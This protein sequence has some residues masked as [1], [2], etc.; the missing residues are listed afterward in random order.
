MG[1][2]SS[3]LNVATRAMMNS[4]NA[5]QTVSHNIASKDVEG[6]SRQ[7]VEF[8]TTP[9]V[10]EGNVQYG[11]GSRTKTVTRINNDYLEKQIQT[12]NSKLGTSKGRSENLLRV[13]SI[14]N[15]QMRKGVNQFVTEFFNSFRELANSP[16][17]QATRDLVKQTAN[18]VTEDFRRVSDQLKQVQHDVDI[19]LTAHTEEVNSML[20]EIA[21]LNGVIEHIEFT[22]AQANDERDRRDQVLKELGQKMNIRYSEG[23]SGK[24]NV[25]AGDNAIVVSG[26]E[27]AEL[28]AVSSGERGDKREGNVDIVFKYNHTAPSVIT[29]QITGGE[30]GGAIEVRDRTI[31]KLLDRMDKLAYELADNVNAAHRMGYNK[32]GKTQQDFF[33]LKGSVRGSAERLALSDKVEKD[34]WS[35]SAAAAPEAPGDNRVANLISSLQNQ[36]LMEKGTSTFNDYYNGIVSEMAVGVRHANQLVEHQ[37]NIVEQLKN[38]RENISGVNLDEEA[39]KMIEYQKAFDASARLIRTADEMLDTVLNLRR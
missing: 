32:Y 13:E 18:A 20:R 2:V 37:S 11:T 15:D 31:N 25:L 4:Q 36:K 27:Y 5:L 12:E 6:Y 22:G 7:R 9:A 30:M 14:Y 39:V 28:S 38:I 17:S 19:Q 21:Y 16:D 24:V 23:D 8:E 3:V 35:I 26:G 33:N 29:D 1:K 34:V 10:H